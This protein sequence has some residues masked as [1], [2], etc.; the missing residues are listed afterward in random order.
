MKK[1][2]WIFFEILLLSFLVIF[3]SIS[4]ILGGIIILHIIFN[5]SYITAGIIW[6]LISI[7]AF[8][9][10]MLIDNKTV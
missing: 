5:L 8:P 4:T 6:I 9:I 7:S 2:I 3:Y 1:K 10:V